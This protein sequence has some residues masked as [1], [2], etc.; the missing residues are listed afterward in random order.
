MTSY[1]ID[2]G[3][4]YS[5]VAKI[6]DAGRAVVLKNAVGEDTTPSVVYFESPENVLVGRVAKDSALI[7]P[8]LVA[9]LVKREMGK[10]DVHWEYHGE[11]HTPESVSALILRELAQ[12]A[13]EQA[14]EQVRD[15][16]I[17]VPAYFGL[18]ER[19]ATRRAGQMAGL[20]VLDVLAEPVA[21][22]LHY[23]AM[24]DTRATRHLLVYD[25]GGG[26]FDTTVI[27]LSG[28]DVEVVCTDGDHRLGGADWDTQ[29]MEY[30][31][32]TFTAEHPDID[33]GTDD[34]G[35]QDLAGTVEK[36][37]K[38]LSQAQSRKVVLRFG[39]QALPI[40]VTRA[41][42]EELTQVLLERTLEITK[43]TI[44]VA[45]EKG[46][47][48]FDEVLLVGGMT[49]MPVITQALSERF[50]LAP[51]LHE[52][53]LAVAKGAALFAVV[54][55]VKVSMPA[56][57]SPAEAHQAARQ[58]ADQLGLSVEQVEGLAA[59]KVATVVPRAF[60]IKA[61]DGSDPRAH[62]DPDHAPSKIYHLLQANTPLPAEIEPETFYTVQDNQRNVLVEVWE[63]AGS[64]A[65]D[66]L[67]NNTH[68]GEGLLTDL[69]PRPRGTPFDVTF[70]MSETGLLKVHAH[71]KRSGREV[72]FEIQ[73][74]GLT[75]EQVRDAGRAVARYAVSG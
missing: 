60:G 68:I 69:P 41:K 17:T 61:L 28:D 3:T 57:A 74:G 75:D 47:E 44:E 10:S 11:R 29:I 37:K 20:E 55:Q 18:A 58:V 52:P 53:D 30:L 19:E 43:R 32:D 73:I 35:M 26:T 70:W 63:Q 39:G 15:V 45:R 23:Q 72:K 66:E 8:D 1:G 56:D 21:A 67:A 14:G 4:T 65:S 33:P 59:K 25:L 31:V 36:L 13:A 71:E 34:Q 7:A 40:E 9:Q 50:G 62:T 64:L 16:V 51:K 48:R 12:A 27:R 42:L 49:R 2:L 46:V 22:A 6:D 5:C 54:K 38:D 24:N